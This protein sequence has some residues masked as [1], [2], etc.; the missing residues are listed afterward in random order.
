MVNVIER[1]V[2]PVSGWAARRAGRKGAGLSDLVVLG[3]FMSVVTTLV[4]YR[5][6]YGN[7]GSELPIVF[8]A[9]DP[10]YLTNDFYTNWAAQFGPRYY[11][12]K[13]M[14]LLA[15]RSTLDEV[16]LLLTV[17]SN[18]VLAVA[19]GLLAFE[20]FGSKIAPVFAALF[21]F[22][23]DTFQLGYAGQLAVSQLLASTLVQPLLIVILWA[24]VSGRVYLCALVSG[25]ASLLHPTIGLE[26]GAVGLLLALSFR[27]LRDK[28]DAT[29]AAT[30]RRSVG[31][32]A[33]FTSFAALS[34]VPYWFTLQ[35][36]PDQFVEIET[37]FRHPHHTLASTFPLGEYVRACAF[38]LATAFAWRWYR[39]RQPSRPQ[40]LA[41]ALVLLA[42]PALCLVGYVFVE[43]VPVRAFAVARPFR[44]LLLFKSIGLVLVAGA[45]ATELST[46][47]GNRVD[48]L[49]ILLSALSPFTLACA[50]G[51]KLAR[52]W[53]AERT[54]VL[55]RVADPRAILLFVV[56]LLSTV[57][58]P[59]AVYFLRYAL[60]TFVALSLLAFP[61]WAARTAVLTL[62]LLV[63]GAMS[64][65]E[66]RSPAFLRAL[67]PRFTMDDVGG[68]EAEVARWARDNTTPQAIFLVPPSMGIFRLLAERAVVVDF[69][70]FPFQDQAMVEWRERLFDCYGKPESTSIGFRAMS[71]LEG[72]YRRIDDTHLARLATRYG[73][74][75]AVLFRD[76]PVTAPILFENEKFKV[77]PLAADA[78]GGP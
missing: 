49:T 59:G 63:V 51:L 72:N 58:R 48:A 52:P 53:L 40:A 44:L 75:F 31:A 26:G 78:S 67:Q 62:T 28:T 21:V 19:S 61:G 56:L 36:S 17:A 11:F 47:R 65:I 73:C 7:H 4:G 2:A 15:K 14:A 1:H 34:V 54:R 3:V 55:R 76:T 18:L 32:L 38:M 30:D 9:M 46:P 69:K 43:L 13:L 20:L 66:P 27:V 41:V 24:A 35:T 71:D 45:V 5:Y 68:P 77:V 57:A 37:R 39:A 70:A 33:V 50:F 42:L 8:R 22:T 16:Y 10:S 12:A 29:T 6:G 60:F 64:W 25:F 23:I 74:S